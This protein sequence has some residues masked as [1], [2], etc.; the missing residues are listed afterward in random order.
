MAQLSIQVDMNALA[1]AQANAVRQAMLRLHNAVEAVLINTA[2][3]WQTAVHKAKL[4][5]G[6]RERYADS[7]SWRMTG[8]FTGVVEASYRLAGQ[9][10]D[11][12]PPYDLKQMLNT[13]LKVRT[14][15]KGERY[16]IVPFRHNTP[17]YDAHAPA[18][19]DH[20]YAKAKKLTFS[21]VTGMG[22]RDS[23][24]GAFGLGTRKLLQ[25]PQAKYAWGTRLPAGMMGP[26]PRGKVD[27]YAGMVRFKD[28]S[29]KSGPKSM[30]LTFRVMKEGSPG[31]IIPS[32]P[33]L[34]LA[35]TVATKMTPYAQQEFAA[36]IAG[37]V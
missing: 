7:I 32:R 28:T 4:W 23:G 22:T 25:V 31:W 34:H 37:T 2:A 1:L 29:S 15:K 36:A 12:R 18:M 9:I 20:V 16:L 11:G 21:Q 14:T 33:G 19:P 24:T 35:Q 13:S 27:R 8:P 30:Y 3:E 6:E 26:N 10:D 5:S 17:G